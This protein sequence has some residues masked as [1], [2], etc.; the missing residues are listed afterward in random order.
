MRNVNNMKTRQAEE[1]SGKR[2][3]FGWLM[4]LMLMVCVTYAHLIPVDVLS[5]NPG[6][7]VLVQYIE[8]LLPAIGGHAKYS[9]IPEVFRVYLS[10][11]WI[12]YPAFLAW[13]IWYDFVRSKLAP[14]RASGIRALPMLVGV[15]AF[16]F[17]MIYVL[18]FFEPT[19]APNPDIAARG[20]GGHFYAAIVGS[21]TSMAAISVVNFLA[22]SVFLNMCYVGIK[23]LFKG[24]K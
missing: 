24:G 19:S 23:H 9:R 22:L 13:F 18:G 16:T 8:S 12:V 7:A 17:L 14:P 20:R 6:L 2:M 10:T 4:I 1:S 21:R 3:G 11:L 5:R 15:I